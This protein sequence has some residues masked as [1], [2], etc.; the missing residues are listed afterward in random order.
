MRRVLDP[1]LVEAID[2]L[3]AATFSA[4]VWRVTWANREPLAGNFG[5]GRW[6]PDNSF[7]ALY[8]SLDQD[9]AMAEVYFHLSRAPVF[10]SSNMRLNQID[11]TLNHVLEMDPATLESLGLK[12]PLASRIDYAISQSIGAVAH[13]LDF[14][15]IIV[16]SARWACLNLV[17]FM[18]RIDV[19][20]QIRAVGRQEINWP[21]W[22]EK[23]K[24]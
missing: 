9:G 4:T 10:S 5:G 21:A 19:D 12:A 14:Q 6:S 8:T 17:I 22:K 20:K 11:V 3:P 2:A 1:A 16:P 15:G 13:M 18:D 24:A 7:E 23:N